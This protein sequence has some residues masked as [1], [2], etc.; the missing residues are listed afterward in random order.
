MEQVVEQAGADR[1]IEPARRTLHTAH[2]IVRVESSDLPEFFGILPKPLA[3]APPQPLVF[4]RVRDV[5]W[6]WIKS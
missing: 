2:H 1:T 3:T 6:D 5:A 4:V